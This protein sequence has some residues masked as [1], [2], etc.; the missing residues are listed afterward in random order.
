MSHVLVIGSSNTDLVVRSPKL[1]NP[2][3]TV[4][5]GTFFTAAGGKG[6]N[7][8]VAAA[9]AGAQVTFVA[10]LG[11]DDFGQQ[12]L[13][14]FKTEGIDTQWIV[15]DPHH[16]SGVA[17]IIVDD[18]N[19]ENSIV[20]A[21]GANAALSPD[22]I[23]DHLFDTVD[24][25]LLQLET[26]IETVLYAATQSAKHNIR[27]VL[28]PAPA[29]DLPSDIWPHLFLITPNQTET[30]HLT[31]ICPDN[32]TNRQKAA[33]ALFKKGAK[34]VIITLGSQG[35]FLATPQNSHLIPAFEI[36]ATDTTGAGDA[37]NGALCCALS[38][39]HPLESAVRFASA[40]GALTVTQAGA[41]P[42]IPTRQQ[43][44]QVYNI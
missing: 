34:N 28:N 25:C 6:A 9:R 13:K 32:K 11:H 35:A 24:I 19:A 39:N 31:G 30:E 40:A 16:P 26:P 38:Q 20:V 7:Q 15:S 14:N 5:G 3:E 27:V 8:A 2:G 33:D 10:R 44:V 36:K 42:S 23:Q 41:Q 1:P 18:N 4:L 12:A 43:I 37:F 29:T 17:F 22:Q 21:S